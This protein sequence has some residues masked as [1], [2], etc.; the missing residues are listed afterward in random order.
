MSKFINKNADKFL[1][2]IEIEKDYS[3]L[4]SWVKNGCY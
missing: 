2:L 3:D 1:D 4:F